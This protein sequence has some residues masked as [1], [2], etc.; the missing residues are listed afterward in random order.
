M[1]EDY[2]I[3]Q[4]P[5]YFNYG[6]LD[7][8]EDSRYSCLMPWHI[9]QVSHAFLNETKNLYINNIIDATAN[10]G[11]DSILLRHLYPD[12]NITSIEMNPNT[13]MKLHHNMTNLNYIMN[14]D[15]KDIQVINIDSLDYIFDNKADLIYFDPPWGGVDYKTKSF[16]DLMLSGI[17]LTNIIDSL[18]GIENVFIAVK[19]PANINLMNFKNN[20]NRNVY[21]KTYYI[22]TASKMNPKVSYTLTFIKLL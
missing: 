11:C 19:L 14:D 8:A 6:L 20:I 3:K 12:A 22:Y 18:L 13:A 15:V 9:N 4:S 16:N 7:I 5:Y 21:F 1:F 2:I 10:I 17:Y